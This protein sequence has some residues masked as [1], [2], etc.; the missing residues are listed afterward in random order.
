[1]RQL[2]AL[3]VAYHAVDALDRCLSA[4]NDSFETVV[5][6]NSSDAQ[7]AATAR[8]H[9]ARYV[10]P[11][12]N[13]GFS[14]GVNLAMTYADREAD[15]LLLNPDA[16]IS[17]DAVRV[18]HRELRANPR[19]A[20]LTPRL[21]GPLGAQRAMWPF[22]SPGRLWREATGLTRLYPPPDEFA[23]GAVLVIRREA[24]DEI[25]GF[26]E[27]FFLYAEETDWQRRASLRGWRSGVSE[28]R[29]QHIGAGTSSDSVHRESLFHRGTEIYIKK[30]FG[31]SGWR[32]YRAAAIIGAAVRS[33]AATGQS[34]AAA[35]ER[36][37]IY[38]RGRDLATRSEA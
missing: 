24:L 7:V 1:M 16:V 19:L 18:L 26:D 12:A 34:R 33:L 29:A 23:V 17:V 11:G 38:L 31:P 20:A 14:S 13:L 37:R 8:K 9:N 4:L 30:W 5:V 22:P 35:R 3:V 21:S 25:G 6:D 27:R 36:L 10:D 2:T 28:V 32:T 15:V